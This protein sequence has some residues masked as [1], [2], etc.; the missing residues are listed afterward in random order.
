M[1]KILTFRAG[2][3]PGGIGMTTVV[4]VRVKCPDSATSKDGKK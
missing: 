1:R 3:L 2:L 4:Y